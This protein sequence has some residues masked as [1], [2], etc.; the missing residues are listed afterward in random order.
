VD[1]WPSLLSMK[2]ALLAFVIAFSVPF[3][4]AQAS[5][6]Y[7]QLTDSSGTVTFNGAGCVPAGSFTTTASSTVVAGDPGLLVASVLVKNGD[8]SSNR[9]VVEVYTGANCTGSLIGS[10]QSTS[11]LD[12]VIGEDTFFSLSAS[13]G[14]GLSANTTYY[15]AFSGIDSPI[16]YEA[17]TNLSEDFF[18]GYLT[19]DGTGESIPIAPGLPGFSNTGIA[20][21]STQVYCNSNFSTSSG[22]LDNLGQ[23]ISLGFCNVGV[24]LFIPDQTAIDRFVG[25]ASSSQTKIPFSYFYQ[26]KS[27]Y[28]NLIAT[29]SP[30]FIDIE[31]PLHNIG[32]GSST[33]LGNFLPNVS[34][35]STSTI[36]TY[37]PDSTRSVLRTLMSSVIWL[38]FAYYAYGV[39]TR[40]I[41][42]RV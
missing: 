8:G 16:E 42:K 2:K 29:T 34:A 15:L 31:L 7:Q 32:I 6:I 37:I 11:F 41:A 30:S 20:T 1:Y 17:R 14:F 19:A 25:I 28:E 10:Y 9:A 27:L 39:V 12:V 18:Y 23:S 13:S 40:M 35:F 33:A 24:F 36:S 38:L 5:T 22:L 21:T 26:I 4:Y 3:S